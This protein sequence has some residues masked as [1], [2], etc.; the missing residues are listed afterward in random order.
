MLQRSDNVRE[1]P[2]KYPVKRQLDI[3]GFVVQEGHGRGDAELAEN[4]VAVVI[5]PDL[6]DL[7]VHNAE[8]AVA[9]HQDALSGGTNE[10]VAF[11]GMRSL[12]RPGN[13]D[14]IALNAHLIGSHTE[15]GSGGAPAFSLGHRLIEACGLV[16][17]VH[18]AVFRVNLRDGLIAA[19]VK[20][21]I[22]DTAGDGLV[23]FRRCP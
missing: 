14:N 15:I 10:P 18:N 4:F 2:R 9:A 1:R 3:F 6:G 5:V 21:V 23:L 20:K 22:E 17:V 13:G 16:V 19:A 7:A 8:A 11:A 12:G